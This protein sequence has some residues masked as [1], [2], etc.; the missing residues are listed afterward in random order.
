MEKVIQYPAPTNSGEFTVSRSRYKI[1]NYVIP[2]GYSRRDG[3]V[4]VD[5]RNLY[6]I[7]NWPIFVRNL[8]FSK[9]IKEINTNKY[10]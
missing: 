5:K 4:L 2:V 10:S 1:L 3:R 6:S 9:T 8:I 7:Y